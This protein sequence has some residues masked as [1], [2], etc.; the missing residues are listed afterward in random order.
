MKIKLKT[1]LITRSKAYF[2]LSL[3][4]AVGNQPTMCITSPKGWLLKTEQNTAIKVY[5]RIDQQ[6]STIVLM[7]FFV[8]ACFFELDINFEREKKRI[9]Y[10]ADQNLYSVPSNMPSNVPLHRPHTSFL[11]FSTFI[12]VRYFLNFPK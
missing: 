7:I 9:I 10:G 8:A 11:F 3:C 1:G 4:T 5:H 6:G 12:S 2:P